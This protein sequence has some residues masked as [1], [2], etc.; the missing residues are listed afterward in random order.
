MAASA[1]AEYV[2][3]I[4]SFGLVA[5]NTEAPGSL[6]VARRWLLV[7][8]LKRELAAHWLLPLTLEYPVAVICCLMPISILMAGYWPPKAGRG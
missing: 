2:P 1:N 8:L 6:A 3:F 4:R 7:L 5:Q